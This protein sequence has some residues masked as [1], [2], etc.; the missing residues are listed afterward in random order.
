MLEKSNSAIRAVAI[1]EG[2]KGVV[3]LLAATGLLALLHADLYDLSVR[4]VEHAHLDPASK[5]PGIFLD[6]VSRFAN[7]KV[8]LLAIGAALYSLI[9]LA[10]AYGLYYAKSWAEWLA[11][12]SGAI[13]VPFEVLELQ[14]HPSW[15]SVSLL[16]ANLGVVAIMVRA[17]VK[18]RVTG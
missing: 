12:G 17:L 16:L 7:T 15:L 4:L 14:R 9:R 1:F 18:R 3:A 2:C 6:A 8:V 11:A 13:Y 5:Y 10:E